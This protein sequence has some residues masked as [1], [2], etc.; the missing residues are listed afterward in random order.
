MTWDRLGLFA[1]CYLLT[2]AVELPVLLV[3][4]SRRHPVWVRLCAGVWL[5][6]CTY[7]IVWFVLPPILE[8]RWLYLLVAETS[9]PLAECAVFWFAFVRGRA[10]DRSATLRDLAAIVLANLASFLAGEG[11]R[12]VGW[13]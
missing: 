5:T 13:L 1:L 10:G 8:D 11:L 9:A 7:P 12:L 3:G 6:A 4:L 2:V